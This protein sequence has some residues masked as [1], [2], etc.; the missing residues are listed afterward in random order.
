MEMKR[1]PVCN[2]INIHT[3]TPPHGR[4][5]ARTRAHKDHKSGL[6]SSFHA[7]L[8]VLHHQFQMITALFSLRIMSFL[9]QIA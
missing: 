7:T 8:N 4:L 1:V 9:F 5:C 6:S 3:H 2:R